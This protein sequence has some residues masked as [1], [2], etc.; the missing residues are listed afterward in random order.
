MWTR[1]K[2]ILRRYTS[3]CVLPNVLIV[4]QISSNFI[5]KCSPACPSMQKP[6]SDF[7]WKVTQIT[8]ASLNNNEKIR[9]KTVFLTQ[10][11]LV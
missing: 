4:E 10:E 2:P 11:L 3:S 1:R 7:V 5:E 6:A 8:I 9:G